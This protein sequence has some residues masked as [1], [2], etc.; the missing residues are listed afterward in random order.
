MILRNLWQLFAGA[1]AW[2]L[3]VVQAALKVLLDAVLITGILNMVVCL[4]AMQLFPK[5]LLIPLG[6]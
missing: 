3:A 6:S 4:L 1:L 5:T 2:G